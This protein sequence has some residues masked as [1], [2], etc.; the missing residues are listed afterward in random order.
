MLRGPGAV[1]APRRFRRVARFRGT[2][3]PGARRAG[4][5]SAAPGVAPAALHRFTLVRPAALPRPARPGIAAPEGVTPSVPGDTRHPPR[6]C[7]LR[8][9][10]PLCAHASHGSERRAAHRSGVAAPRSGVPPH[11]AIFR[12]G[13]PG[14]R[15]CGFF[16]AGRQAR[17]PAARPP[18]STG[19][20]AP[21][22]IPPATVPPCPGGVSRRSKGVPLRCR[23]T[24][25]A[26]PRRDTVR[27]DRRRRPALPA[28]GRGFFG[29]PR[30]SG[31]G[32]RRR[33][34]RSPSGASSVLT[35]AGASGKGR[36]P[37]AAVSGPPAGCSRSASAAC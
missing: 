14:E 12:A 8:P 29:A 2:R 22:S 11:S 4:A 31:S 32:T 7:R 13:I 26:S 9:G 10:S 24:G 1:A 37:R 35:P 20:A 30:L 34:R 19:I 15:R 25:A 28:S 27:R 36:R 6:R 18:A 17:H 33:S 5:A 23:T 16:V 3:S 21:R